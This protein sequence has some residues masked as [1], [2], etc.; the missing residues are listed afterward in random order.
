MMRFP[1]TEAEERLIHHVW[2]DPDS[3][4]Q[5]R[6]EAVADGWGAMTGTPIV[7]LSELN[8]PRGIHAIRLSEFESTLTMSRPL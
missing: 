3:G 2:D 8:K 5:Y 7:F 1:T 6:V 4:L